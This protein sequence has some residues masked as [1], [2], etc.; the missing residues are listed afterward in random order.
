[1]LCGSAPLRGGQFQPQF[2]FPTL[3]PQ[4]VQQSQQTPSAGADSAAGTSI[5][6]PNPSGGACPAARFQQSAMANGGSGVR[7]SFQA[8][9]P[10]SRV[11]L[12][13]GGA[14]QPLNAMNAR[15]KQITPTQW[16]YTDAN[17]PGMYPFFAA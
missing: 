3:S 17:A 2:G 5:G 8:N 7:F 6:G 15:M 11:D 10:L 1:M 13:W 16:E 14:G 9:V 12:H 4:A